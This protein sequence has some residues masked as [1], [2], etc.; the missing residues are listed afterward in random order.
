M[1]D[2]MP[3]LLVLGG[4]WFLGR[5]VV[6][7]AISDGWEVT[8]FRRG[9]AG[10]GP[11]PD[12]VTAVRGDYGNAGDLARLATYGPFDA[13]VDNLAFTPRET[14][15]CEPDAGPDPGHDGDPAP[16][17]YGFGKAGCERAVLQTFGADRSVILRPGSHPWSRCP[18]R[19]R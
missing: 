8:I 11:D 3:R 15:A 4:S 5:A 16:T 10:S 19:S 17:T 13:V 6:C 9:R 2:G 7:A 18:A 12:G 1:M 14:L